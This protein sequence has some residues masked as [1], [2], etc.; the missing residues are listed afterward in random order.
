MPCD[1]ISSDNQIK[2]GQR[3]CQ[4]QIPCQQPRQLVL[5]NYENCAIAALVT[6]DVATADDTD[7]DMGMGM[8]ISM[9]RDVDV[10]LKPDGQHEQRSEFEWK[11]HDNRRLSI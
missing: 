7:M 1:A 2:P 11:W 9:G 8:G 5:T 3:A 4:L 10:D 6:P